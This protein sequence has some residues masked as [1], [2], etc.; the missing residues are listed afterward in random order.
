MPL[1]TYANLQTSILRWLG[2]P[3]DTLIASDVPDMIRLFE[4]E[5]DRRLKTR[6]SDGFAELLHDEDDYV[7]P[8]PSDFRSLRS[9]RFSDADPIFNINYLTPEQLNMA[10]RRFFTIEGLNLRLADIGGEHD[11]IRIGYMRGLTPLSASVPLNWLLQNCPDAY[12]FGSLVEAEAFIGNDD[13]AAG[14]LQR[15]EAA[16]QSIKDADHDAKYGGGG[17][18]MRPDWLLPVSRPVEGTQSVVL[19]ITLNPNAT[20]TDLVNSRIETSSYIQLSPITE[21]AAQSAVLGIWVIPSNG[22]ALI[23]HVSYDATDQTFSVLIR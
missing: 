10:S 2:R 16:F 7:V 8:L 21:S 17:L 3:G 12:L 14:W 4:V 23:H 22:S 6:W 19:T 5:A 11:T 20:S 1:D 15:R 18:Q 13:R 9:I